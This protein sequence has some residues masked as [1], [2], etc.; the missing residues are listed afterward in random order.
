[1]DRGSI[2]KWLKAPGKM[3]Q[4]YSF[5][6]VYFCTGCGIIEIPPHDNFQVGCREVW[7]YPCSHPQAG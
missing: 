2:K 4:K 6:V 7:S 1:M 3:G 5:W